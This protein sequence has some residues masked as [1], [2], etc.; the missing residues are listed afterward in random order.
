M[1]LPEVFTLVICPY[2]AS[3]SAFSGYRVSKFETS[4]LHKTIK[5]T[6][7]FYPESTVVWHPHRYGSSI[8][9]GILPHVA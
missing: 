2:L 5:A 9:Q 6:Y 4:E 7:F 8:F 3:N 1:P